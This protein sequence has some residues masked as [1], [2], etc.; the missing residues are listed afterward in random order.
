MYDIYLDDTRIGSITPDKQ[1]TQSWKTPLWR[2]T[3]EEG[4]K[5]I[6]CKLKERKKEVLFE[7]N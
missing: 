7:D 6:G 5:E 3:I 1:F 4:L 2:N